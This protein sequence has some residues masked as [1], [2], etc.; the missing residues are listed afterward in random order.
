MGQ[1]GTTGSSNSTPKSVGGDQP[2]GTQNKEVVKE[3]K[4]VTAR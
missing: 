1:N 3:N 2:V 4:D